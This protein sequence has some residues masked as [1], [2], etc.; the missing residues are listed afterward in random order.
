MRFTPLL[1]I[2]FLS[3]V[4]EVNAKELGKYGVTTE[5]KEEGFLAM[6]AR[7]LKTVNIE[8]HQEKMQKQAKER[9]NNPRPVLGVTRTK[10]ARSF[11]F[12]PTYT[13]PEDIYLPDGK[14]LH[15]R[16]TKVNPLDY[17]NLDRKMFFID[18]RDQEQIAWLEAQI[19]EYNKGPEVSEETLVVVL[20]AGSPL[21]LQ[22]KMKK[23]IYFDQSGELTT[24]FGIRQVPAVL[25]QEG[26]LIRIDEIEL[27]GRRK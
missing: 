26:K 7:K 19:L 12:D 4:S 2:V 15:A 1:I 24:R 17:M 23:K 10:E 16:G 18:A 11:I 21:E 14:L 3:L 6:I 5:V 27:A 25:E 8:E 13:L 9:V 22:D 20:V